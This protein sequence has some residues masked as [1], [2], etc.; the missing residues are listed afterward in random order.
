MF[1]SSFYC[2][3]KVA[4]VYRSNKDIRGSKIRAIWGT[5]TRPH[6]THFPRTRGIGTI[7]GG[8]M[9]IEDGYLEQW[10]RLGKQCAD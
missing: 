7:R 4:F 6:G 5:V 2:G 3:K 1:F 9:G 8:N 10:L